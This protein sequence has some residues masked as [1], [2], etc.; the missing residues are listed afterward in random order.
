MPYITVFA[1]QNGSGKSSATRT[2][3]ITGRY[4]NADEIK[5]AKMTSRRY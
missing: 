5:K 3:V 1:G 4:I 2:A